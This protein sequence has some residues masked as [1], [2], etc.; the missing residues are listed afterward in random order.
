MKLFWLVGCNI[1]K[2]L[3][4][5]YLIFMQLAHWCVNLQHNT[6]KCLKLFTNYK[7]KY[8]LMMHTAPEIQSWMMGKR[9]L[10]QRTLERKIFIW[11]YS[12]TFIYL[13][14]LRFCIFLFCKQTCNQLEVLGGAASRKGRFGKGD[15]Q[16]LSKVFMSLPVMA[17]FVARG[18]CFLLSSP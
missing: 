11:F 15:S 8:W 6:P 4:V 5:V 2:C 14:K 18:H 17:M 3:H 1:L 12:A 9:L 10:H 13:C 7:L 16:T